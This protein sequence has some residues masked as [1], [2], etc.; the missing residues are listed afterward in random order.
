MQ[1]FARH[2]EVEKQLVINRPISISE[3]VI[4]RRNWRPR[5]GETF[6]RGGD[7]CV[8]QVGPTTYTLDVL[9]PEFI[10]PLRMKRSWTPY[11]FG[12]PK[13]AAAVQT[14]LTQLG[15]TDDYALFMSAPIFA[16][17]VPHLS[18]RAMGLDAQDNLLKHVFYHDIPGLSTYYDYF[19][20][21]ADFLS[22]NSQE[23]TDWL[24]EKRPDAVHISNGVDKEMFDPTAAYETPD[25]MR[26]F[27][28]PVVGY[29]G[30]MMELFDVE[31]M[32]HVAQKLPD[33]EFVFIGQQLNP[34]WMKALWAHPNVHYLGDKP[35]AQLPHY[36]AAF[37]VCIIPYSR[38]RQHGGDP[39]KF[40][41]YLAIGK[42]VVTTDIGGVGVFKEFPQVRI[43]DDADG[44]V[45]GVRH[46]TDAARE[47][48]AI[49]AEELPEAY[50]WAAKADK[51]IQSL[52]V[53]Q[54]V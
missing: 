42:P 27:T 34:E 11:I 24:N 40:Y 16:P 18:P 46:F 19:I 36:L 13:V 26:R 5:Q 21:H 6:F 12:Q 20:E 45:E 52:L 14:A 23:T 1:E 44:F 7:V 28:G 33:V 30:K 49:P 47:G 9:I 38:Q 4:L 31:L 39:I 51:I 37:D 15:M 10:R 50:T 8:T 29:A 41:E 43:P 54:G 32:S 53:K 25:D 3:M 35:Y 2:P 22:A 48:R 17:L